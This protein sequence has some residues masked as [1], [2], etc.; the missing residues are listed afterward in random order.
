MTA[1]RVLIVDDSAFVRQVLTEI[2]SSDP[3]ID[4]VG[5]APN[6]IVARDMIKSL[7]PD[8]VTLDI[9]MPRMDGLAFLDKIMS[10]RPMPVLM[11]SSL[12]QKGADTAVRALEM[13]AF[14][15]IAKPVVGLVEGLPALRNEIIGKVKAAAVANIRPRSGEQ[16]RPVQRPGVTYNSSEKIIAIGASTGGVEALQELLTA[17]PSDVPAV[18]VTQHMPAMFTASFASRL[19][20]LCAVTVKQAENGE[21]VLPGHVYIAPGGFHLELARNGANYVCRVHDEPAVSGHRPSV[22]VLFRSVAHAAGPNAIGIILTGM[23]RDGAMGLL[24]MRSAGAPTIGQDEASCVVYGMPK[25]ARDNGAV[26]IEL[27]LGKIV[28]HVLKR[29]EALAARGVRV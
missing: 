9:E 8:V 11:I 5:A 10:L 25:A 19:N 6:P 7:T 27:P 28:D 17:L 20:Q 3:A 13:G 29:C 23:G 15:C 21:R 4:V 18:V 1:I 14:D 24:E 2:L 22:D 12:T 16:V 26:E